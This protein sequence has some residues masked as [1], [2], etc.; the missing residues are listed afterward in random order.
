MLG[1]IHPHLIFQLV[2]VGDGAA[3]VVLA[4]QVFRAVTAALQT[5][6]Q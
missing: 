6:L 5:H 4:A 3:Q 1:L 2:V